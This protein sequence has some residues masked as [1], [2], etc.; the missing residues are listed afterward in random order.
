MVQIKTETQID[1]SQYPYLHKWD[2]TRRE[3][4]NVYEDKINENIYQHQRMANTKWLYRVFYPRYYQHYFLDL[5]IYK[6]LQSLGQYSDEEVKEYESINPSI[7]SDLKHTFKTTFPGYGFLAGVVLQYIPIK[8][9][10]SLGNNLTLLIAPMIIQWAY[11]RYN[12]AY[13]HN[14]SQFLSYVLQKRIAQSQLEH[15]SGEINA[16]Q[17]D[18]FKKNFPGMSPLEVF[19]AYSKL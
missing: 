10:L 15:Y 14:S 6:N 4:Y 1:K 16:E 8:H 17:V 19:K 12:I 7:R 13:K 3:H 2:L 18:L 9:K 11:S 5:S